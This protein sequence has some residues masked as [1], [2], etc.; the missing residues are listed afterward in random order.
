MSNLQSAMDGNL[1]GMIGINGPS[2][3]RGK[4]QLEPGLKLK[5]DETTADL[6]ITLDDMNR[7][8]EVTAEKI[9]E[10]F[11]KFLKEKRI[12]KASL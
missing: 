4:T 2:Y 11:M 10:S 5:P 12:D 7:G 8:P 6:I 3:E 9:F 1:K